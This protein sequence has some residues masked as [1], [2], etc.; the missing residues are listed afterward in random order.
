MTQKFG[1]G[2]MGMGPVPGIAETMEF[3]KRAW[4]SFQ[5][6]ASMAPTIDLEEID[7]RIA[8][9][10]TVEQWLTM[11]VAML[12]SAIHGLE[13]QR[14]TIAAL[15]A[16][17]DAVGSSPALDPAATACAM[18][19]LATMAPGRRDSAPGP[20]A[21]S[22]STATEDTAPAAAAD[23]NAADAAAANAENPFSNPAMNPAAWWNLLQG[24][25]AQVVQSAITS[26]AEAAAATASA[27]PAAPAK[28]RKRQGSG[29]TAS[30]SSRTGTK[31]RAGTGAA[32]GR[33]RKAT[34]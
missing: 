10:R 28:P 25:F 34:G 27:T 21:S 15:T 9:L 11:N 26:A 33:P 16:F 24:Q 12:Q 4:S 32:T 7:K 19:S 22:A 17:G 6:P 30:K 31:R 8:D 13:V 1:I 23:A 3:V 29:G 14:S 5:L 2:A 20:A 18:S